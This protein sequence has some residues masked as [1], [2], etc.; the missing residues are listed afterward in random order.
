MSFAFQ[1]QEPRLVEAT[2]RLAHAVASLPADPRW[3]SV[4]P[5][6]LLVGGFVRDVLGG[7]HP[8]DV[9]VEVYG[10]APERLEELLERAS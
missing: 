4:A 1:A 10:V 2:E 6:A 7:G 5:R 9:D 3:P 8:K